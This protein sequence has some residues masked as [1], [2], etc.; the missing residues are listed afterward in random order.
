MISTRKAVNISSVPHRS[1]FRYPGGKT[2]FIPEIRRWLSNR[3]RVATFIEPFSGGATVGLT[4]VAENLVDKV[5]LVE[6]D[7]KVVAVWRTILG[8][9]AAWLKE[10]I[11]SF[12]MTE[13]NCNQLFQQEKVTTKDEGVRLQMV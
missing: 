8:N 2:W 13:S 1:P 12:E 9:D 4:A 11:L 10:N 5:I 6:R 3:D 7:P